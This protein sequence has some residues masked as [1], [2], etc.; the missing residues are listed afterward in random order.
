[1]SGAVVPKKTN[2]TIYE[3]IFSVGSMFKKIS[4]HY[5]EYAG[6]DKTYFNKNNFST[7]IKS[8]G[9]GSN[10]PFVVRHAHHKSTKLIRAHLKPLKFED[11]V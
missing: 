6:I 4:H 1:M 8:L 10:S 7:K 9:F 11:A 3:C 5:Y 2:T